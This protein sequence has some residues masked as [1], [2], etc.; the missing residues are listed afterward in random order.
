[1][2]MNAEKYYEARFIFDKGRTKVWK[3]INEYLQP[4]VPPNGVALDIGCG[5]ADFIN[6]I[7]AQKKYAI[8]LNP[9]MNKFIKDRSTAFFSQSVL[10]ELPIENKSLDIVF[11]SNLFEHFND[12]ELDV[13]IK[14][15]IT[16]LKPTGKLIL[17]QPN[18]YFAY[19]EYWDDYTHKKAFS[20]TSLNDFLVSHNFDIIHS[21]KQFLPFSLKSRLPKS[22]WLTK[23]YLM[24]PVKPMGKQMLMIAQ[25][26]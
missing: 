4:F 13:L 20:H 23:L 25:K 5:Y 22:Y 7:E 8:D 16:K 11:A 6:G 3:A 21:K 1:M 14:N 15:I 18:I 17:I 10:N 19:R 26:K 24:S 9:E 12:Q 2:N